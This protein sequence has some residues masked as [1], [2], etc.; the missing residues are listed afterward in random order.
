MELYD[1]LAEWL[2]GCA[3]NA[4]LNFKLVSVNSHRVKLPP[5]SNSKQ[6]IMLKTVFFFF[7]HRGI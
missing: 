3:Q 7:S 5:V 6:Q 1:W 4:K 2:I